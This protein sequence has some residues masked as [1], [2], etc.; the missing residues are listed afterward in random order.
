[1]DLI[2]FNIKEVFEIK[3]RNIYIL[4]KNLHNDYTWEEAD[5][6]TDFLMDIKVKDALRKEVILV[7]DNI[8]MENLNEIMLLKKQEEVLVVDDND[9]IVGII[10]RNDL[11]KSLAR[12]IDLKT[13]I[14][15]IMTSDVIFM[16]PDK[17]LLQA[18]S[19]MRN[20]AISRAPVLDDNGQIMG[21]LTGKGICDT[22]SGQLEKVVNFQ[23]LIMDNIK[24]AICILNDKCEILAY[25]NA[26][27]QLFKPSKIFELTPH[28]FLPGELADKIKKGETPLDE[29]FFEKD[30]RKFLLK[31][32]P[33][34]FDDKLCGM[35]MNIEE[36]SD[37]INIITELEKAKHRIL[38]LEK[39][40]SGTQEQTAFGKLTS[41]SPKMI[42]VIELAKRTAPTDVPILIKGESGTGKS[43]LAAT[44]HEYSG[45]RNGAF[46][47]V[48]CAAI[49]VNIF[50]SELFGID[51]GNYNGTANPGKIGLIELANKGT[52][53]FENIHEMPVNIQMKLKN[54]IK[55]KTFY[56]IGGNVP[57]RSDVRIIASTDKELCGSVEKQEF[58]EEIY[59]DIN[60]S[61][62]VP[63]L[64]KRSEDIIDI[65]KNFIREFEQH[66]NKTV[67]HIDSEVLKIFM[68]YNWPGNIRQLKNVVERLVILCENGTIT[69][70][71]LPKYMKQ[72]NAYH[73]ILQDVSDLD[74]A[75]DIA[76]RQV[77]IE[78]LKKCSYNKTKTAEFLKVSRSTLYNKMR[79]YNIQ[80]T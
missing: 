63:P 62:E 67:E 60:V 76:E 9:E 79:E 78:A 54:F 46:V 71:N 50:E 8:T 75:S 15:A 26:F 58:C 10:T 77:I 47:R 19:E 52:I 16:Y 70:D 22:F 64:R 56:K 5:L 1:M 49:P 27:E 31:T 44:I 41:K 34:N 61:M 11:A 69:I 51:V 53:F 18:R 4:Y 36:I 24:T 25:N 42:E 13:E 29:I 14:N 12:G 28:Y 68:D 35:I 66:Y 33:F 3:C 17:P 37:V 73:P 2:S 55:S 72:E 20:L 7:H 48:N 59:E 65:V 74:Q 57:V 40:L 80:L 32:C 43:M 6:K 39:Q 45:R 21:L 38:F 30:G 23:S